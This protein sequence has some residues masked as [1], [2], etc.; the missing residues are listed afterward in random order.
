M[1]DVWT[2]RVRDYLDEL[3]ELSFVMQGLFEKTQVETS[4]GNPGRIQDSVLALEA[5]LV[6]LETKVAQREELIHDP[7]VPGQGVSLQQ[8]LRAS[9]Q[10][11]HVQLASRAEEVAQTVSET[12]HHAIALFVCQFHL[13]DCSSH[14][15]RLLSHDTLRP[16]YHRDGA[17]P[18]GGG[19]FN[20][21]A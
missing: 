7:Q 21:S 12:N 19:L 3:E 20:K 14:I 18:R 4:D 17:T 5:K 6:D 15:L 10:P 13:Q 8:I 2:H 16:T 11:E 9:D 1:N